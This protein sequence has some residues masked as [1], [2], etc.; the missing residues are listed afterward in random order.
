MTNTRLRMLLSL[1]LLGSLFMYAGDML[2]YGEPWM[3]ELTEENVLAAMRRMSGLRLVAGG[4]LGPFAVIFYCAGF[5]GVSRLVHD[6]YPKQRIAVFVLF[7][8]GIIFGGA[9]HSHFPHLAFVAPDQL[10]TFT[11][12]NDYIEFL[13]N[14]AIVPWLAANILFLYLMLRGRTFCSRYVA[15]AT[16][17]MMTAVYF[18]ILYLPPPFFVFLAGG[19][20]NLPFTIFFA[21]CLAGMR[22]LRRAARQENAV[23]DL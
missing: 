13:T 23:T 22:P 7:S 1:G 17:L 11:A 9:Y 12:M 21:G 15:L 5:Y 19:W 16:P 14:C 8:S 20:G 4:A 6:E 3:A 18:P 2:L 10:D